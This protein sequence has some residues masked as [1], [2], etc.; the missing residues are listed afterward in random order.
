M[1]IPRKIL[2]ALRGGR[3]F[4]I[5]TH[6]NPDGDALGSAL[7]LAEV[8]EAMGK[9]AVI[10]NRDRVPD[11][12]RFL[13]GHEKIS[14]DIE[15]IINSRQVLVLL[16]CNSPERAALEKY[17]FGRSV[18]IDHHQTESEFGDIRFINSEAAATG[19]LIFFIAKALQ[20]DITKEI[21]TNLYASISVDTGT[22][23]YSNTTAEVLRASAELIECGADPKMISEYLYEKW[24]RSRFDLLVSTLNTMEIKKG[25]AIV[26]IT[27]EMFR[28][29]GT[30][31]DETENFANFG[32]MINTVRVSAVFRQ[33][34]S[35]TWKASLRSKGDVN[36]ARVAE[37]FGGGG[38]MNAA[39]F[40]ISGDLGS[41]K[42]KLMA[43]IRKYCPVSS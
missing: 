27:G 5:A 18:V 24:G 22:F 34:G 16:D 10:Y 26:Y 13:P 29:T 25:V 36:V 41:V 37:S 12:Y 1:K 8:L 32:R 31:A 15:G 17:H 9:T 39:G 30:G 3:E 6:I 35:G 42:R 43:A 2:T 7:A 20:A 28:Q 11:N 4:L 33:T 19:L 40:R 21:A 14:H 23:R 38:H